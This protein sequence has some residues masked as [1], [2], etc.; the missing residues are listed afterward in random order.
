MRVYT[1]DKAY[2]DAYGLNSHSDETHP[3]FHGDIIGDWRE[4]F[5]LASSGDDELIIFTSDFDTEYRIT[6]LSQDPGMRSSMSVNGY[7]QSHMS[8]MYMA[9]DIDIDE[10]RRKLKEYVARRAMNSYEE[11]TPE[12]SE[13]T[14]DPPTTSTITNSPDDEDS[15]NSGNKLNSGSIAGIVIAVLVVVAGVAIGLFLYYKKKARNNDFSL[16]EKETQL[17]SI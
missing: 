4:E 14:K 2:T 10:E 5:I 3:L 13:P 6:S 11:P 9:T 15:H 17:I 1:A 16:Q 12:V 8:T 7:K